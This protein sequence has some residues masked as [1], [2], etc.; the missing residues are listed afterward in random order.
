MCRFCTQ[1][2]DGKVW[3]LEA[4]SY[5]ADLD[6]DL[7]RRDYL[8]PLHQRLRPLAVH[9]HR[10]RRHARGHAATCCASSAPSAISRKMQVDHF[11]QPVPI[12]DIEKILDITTSVV[13]LPCLCRTQ[14][15]KAP[16]GVCL[17]ITTR[18][19]D[20]LLAKAFGANPA[21]AD[22]PDVSR[23]DQLTKE[24]TL[25][26]LR[27][28]EARGLMHSVWTFKSPVHRRDLQLRPPERLHGDAPHPRLRHQAHVEGREPDR[29][30]RGEVH[31]VRR[32]RGCVSRSARSPTTALRH[33]AVVDH[34]KCYGCGTCR[35]ACKTEALS[36][37]GP[38][39]SDRD[40]PSRARR[41]VM[42]EPGDLG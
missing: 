41:L 30:R 19:Y 22:G 31:R 16:E 27:A 33:R 12:E 24:E 25:D 10:G 5:S 40:G 29:V 35:A 36:L 7:V 1:H 9:G 14:A 39:R 26:L 4:S 3:Y 20:E 6:S 38:A 34:V 2:G 18:P 32:L 15:G 13:R 42:P 11:G 21:F 23:F 8:T 37:S 28:C 17:A